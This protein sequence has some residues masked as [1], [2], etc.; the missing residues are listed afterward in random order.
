MIF[1]LRSCSMSCID[2]LHILNMSDRRV[3]DYDYDGSRL[4]SLN[5][6][7]NS[8]YSSVPNKR[9]ARLF[10]LGKFFQPTQAY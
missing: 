4:L 8:E 6:L 9:A 1:L 3:K 7:C 2:I 10:I 5:V